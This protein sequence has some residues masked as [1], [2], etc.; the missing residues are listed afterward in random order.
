M[1]RTSPACSWMVLVHA[2]TQRTSG[3]CVRQLAGLA[4]GVLSLTGYPRLARNPAQRD[5]PCGDLLVGLAPRVR[6]GAGGGPG[7]VGAGWA[8]MLMG[9]QVEG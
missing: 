7:A 6:R 5:P 8:I 3:A 4:A 1:R 2:R 9:A